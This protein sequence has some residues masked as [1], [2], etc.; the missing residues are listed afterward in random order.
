MTNIEYSRE[1]SSIKFLCHSL[2]LRLNTYSLDH[3]I[4]IMIKIQLETMKTNDK[5]FYSS[6]EG[7]LKNLFTLTDASYSKGIN[8]R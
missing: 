1:L 6:S 4:T 3:Y 7:V 5:N 8:P 2:F